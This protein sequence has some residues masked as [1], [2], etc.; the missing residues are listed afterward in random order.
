MMECVCVCVRART[1]TLSR[2]SHGQLFAT[3]WTICHQAPLSMGAGEGTS[4]ST[5]GGGQ[6]SLCPCPAI[7]CLG[8]SQQDQAHSSLSPGDSRANTKSH[9][10]PCPGG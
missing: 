5:F 2:F 10:G 8:L 3:L 7:L 1:R 9:P 6:G 4:K